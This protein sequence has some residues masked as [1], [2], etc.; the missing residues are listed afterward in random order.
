MGWKGFKDEWATILIDLSKSKEELFDNIDRSRRKNI[1]T[2][3]ASGLQFVEAQN[4]DWAKWYEIYR[5]V[6]TESGLKPRPIEELK[7]YKLYIA[8]VVDI[9]GG[10]CFEVTE[11]RI[12]FEAFASDITYQQMRVNDFLYWNSILWAK[13]HGKKYVDLGGWQ[14]N[15]S[16]HL[17]GINTFK[18][19]WGGTL[20]FYPVYS[21]NPFYIAGRKLI[22]HS[23]AAKWVADRFKG[24]P[25]AKEKKENNESA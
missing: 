3:E 22:K 18:E 10:G 5:K 17:K 2:A 8:K 24:R 21:Y 9:I 16:G 4:E 1:N 12:R 13:E 19:K 25:V 7:Q 14:I 23:K 20:T 15:A 6:W 11:D